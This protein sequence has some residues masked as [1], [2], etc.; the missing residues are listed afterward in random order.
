MLRAIIVPTAVT[1]TLVLA[2]CGADEGG[3]GASVEPEAA[4]GKDHA[5]AVEEAV[6]AL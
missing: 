2:A 3:A 6:K 5:A 1:I 4:T